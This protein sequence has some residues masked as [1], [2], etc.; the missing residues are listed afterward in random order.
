[1]I[2]L[3]YINNIILINKGQMKKIFLCR[4]PYC[5]RPLDKEGHTCKEIGAVRLWE[6]KREET[7]ALKAYSKEY[8]R[9]FAWI[10]YGKIPKEAFYEWAEEARE[11]RDLCMNGEMSI[12]AFK[13]W[14]EE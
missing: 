2:L 3:T 10:K 11:K 13:A 7:P 14:L 6:K 4:T 9:R 5:D 12:E 8:K 1:M